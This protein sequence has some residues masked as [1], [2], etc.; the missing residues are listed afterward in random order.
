M[1]LPYVDLDKDGNVIGIYNRPQRAGHSRI[2]DTLENESK[3]QAFLA[4]MLPGLLPDPDQVV[5]DKIR[6]K[7]RLSSVE[8]DKMLDRLL[9]KEFGN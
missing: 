7:E 4:L 9:T 5:I 2:E 8:R 1:V 3:I 6:A